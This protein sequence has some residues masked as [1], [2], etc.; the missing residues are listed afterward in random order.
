MPIN[1]NESTSIRACDALLR[2]ERQARVEQNILGS[3]V[4]VIDRLLSRQLELKDAYE[5]LSLKLSGHHQALKV[6]FDQLLCVAAFWNPAAHV[7]ARRHR[8]TLVS[9]NRAISEAAT[10]LAGLLEQHS[11][12]MNHSGFSCNTHYHPLNVLHSAA[13]GNYLYEHWVKDD[14]RCLQGRFDLKYWPTLEEFV[15]ELANDAASATPEPSDPLTAAGTESS[16]ASL[17]DT[18]KSFFTA[19]DDVT[20]TN[21]GF[22][23]DDFQL[24][25]RSAAALLSCALDLGPDEVVDAA[26][27]KRLRQRERERERQS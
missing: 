9:L 22:I 11:H 24:A 16:R 20:V 6:F 14:L 19:L 18:F 2:R 7:Q 25:D 13:A 15:R 3:E 5:E 21:H 27:V 12:V 1:S 10:S 4:R 26:F 23:P 17:A 8:A